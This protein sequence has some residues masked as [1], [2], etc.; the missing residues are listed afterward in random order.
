MMQIDQDHLDVI[1]ELNGIS[2]K[3]EAMI[4]DINEKFE[5]SMKDEGEKV[6]EKRQKKPKK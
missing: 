3:D 2:I 6:T 1:R 5:R 4:E